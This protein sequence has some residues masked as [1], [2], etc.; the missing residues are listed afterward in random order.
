MK[1]WFII[2]LLI[3]VSFLSIEAPAQ[4][5][6]K[7]IWDGAEIVKHQSGKM[8]FTKD[9]KVYKEDSSGKFVSMVVKKGN[10][11]RVYDIEKYNGKV[12]Y[13]MSSGYRV[14]ATDLVIF[15]DVPMNLRVS[16]FDDY[17]WIVSSKEGISKLSRP[18]GRLLQDYGDQERYT[19]VNGKL[20][21]E[22]QYYVGK[23]AKEFISGSD[24]KVLEKQSFPSGYYIATQNTKSYQYPLLTSVFSEVEKNTLIK[25]REDKNM[26][27]NGLVVIDSYIL[28]SFY[29]NYELYDD[30]KINHYDGYVSI[31][32]LKPIEDIQ[33]IGTYYTTKGL[34][35][36]DDYGIPSIPANE[37]V[38]LY[39]T[40]DDHG[41]I[42]YKDEM[43]VVKLEYLSKTP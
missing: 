30:F 35:G 20:Q 40:Q 43:A 12:Y 38:T 1:K 15:K 34:K 18:Y 28:D 31:N 32:K 9:V 37:A 27:L 4:A 11:L 14:Q 7:V 33:P 23:F 29:V 22:Y 10:Y 2:I 6:E 41:I 26:S 3:G 24:V 13:W 8:T 42:S 36:Y 19:V 17:T 21:E 25:V 5:Q 39:L 16:F